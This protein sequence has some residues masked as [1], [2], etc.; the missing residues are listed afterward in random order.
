MLHTIPCCPYGMAWRTG[1]VVPET[2]EA[3]LWGGAWLAVMTFYLPMLKRTCTL[4]KVRST[5]QL[6]P[7][8]KPLGFSS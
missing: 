4:H 8:S 6:E 1:S 7:A 3:G 5:V 2:M